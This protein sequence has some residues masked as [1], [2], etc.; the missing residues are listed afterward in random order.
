MKEPA[1]KDN[2]FIMGTWDDWEPRKMTWNGPSLCEVDVVLRS[3][4][5]SFKLQ[6]NQDWNQNVYPDKTNATIYEEYELMGP[7][8]GGMDTEWTI[9]RDSRDRAQPGARYKVQLLF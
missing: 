7:D 6:K 2:Y 4:A 8:N 5:E 9:G 1:S 3:E